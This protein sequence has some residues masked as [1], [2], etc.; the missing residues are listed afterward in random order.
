MVVEI[1]ETSLECDHRQG[2]RMVLGDKSFSA[3]YWECKCCGDVLEDEDMSNRKRYDAECV[4][5]Q[6][7]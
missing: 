5:F 2:D 6:V 3:S 1:E 7:L 4:R